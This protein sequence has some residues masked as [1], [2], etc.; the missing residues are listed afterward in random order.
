MLRCA[1]Q[2][3][4]LLVANAVGKAM[5]G[6]VVEFDAQMLR[7]RGLDPALA[8]YFREAP[9]FSQ[10]TWLVALEV[11]G[12]PRG[13]VFV[14]FDAQGEPCLQPAL[15]KAAGVRSQA[16]AVSAQRQQCLTLREGL[17]AATVA[18][19]PGKEQIDLLVPTDLLALPQLQSRSFANGGVGGVF[20]YDALVMG[21]QYKGQRSDFR[22]VGSEIGLNAGSWVLR[23]RQSYTQLPDSTRFEHLYAYGTRTLEAYEANVQ[24]GQLNLQSPLFA[25]ESFNGVQI[26]PEGAFAQMRA[27]QEGAR[28]EVEGIAWSPSRIE[29]R[30]N[31]VLIYTTLV[32]GGPFTLRALPL[33]S[34][35]LDLEVS[36]HEQEGQVRRFR[37]PAASL[38]DSQFERADGFNLALGTVRRQ[39]SDDRQAPSFATLGREW[40]LSRALR[41]S[42]GILGGADYLSAGWGLQRQW[43]GDITSGVRQVL[44]SDRDAGIAGHQLQMTVSAVLSPNLS[45]SV[46]AVRRG[47]GFRTLSDTGWNQQRGRAEASGREHWTFALNGS[48]ERWGAFGMT[49]S[50]YTSVDEPPNMRL[51]LSWSQTLPARISLSLSLERGVGDADVYRRG[52]SAYLTVGMP[53]GEQRRARSYLRSDP[54]SG[55]R[56][57]VSM[58][59]VLS[60]T[61]AYSASAEHREAAAPSLGLRVNAL[62]PY[63]HVDLGLNQRAGASEF[64]LG[65]RGG[66][67]LH[68]DGVTLSPYPLRETFAVLK[69]GDRAGLKLYTPQGPVWTDDSGRAVAASL[70]PY[71]TARLEV[72]P[73]SLPR[74]VEVLYGYQ[75]VEAGRGSV[76]HLDFS[77][78]RVRRVLLKAWTLDRQWLPSGLA[79]QDEHG[80][81][82]TTVLEAGT[83]FLPDIKPGQLLRVQLSDS[84][85]C[86]LQFNL[87]E[88]PDEQALIEPVDALC[89]PLNLT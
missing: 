47:Q 30:Q 10:G 87:A 27:A 70:P 17:P 73:L 2:G 51:G 4:A 67:A 22:S 72:D 31:G 20:N 79:V 68:R 63:T 42:G 8:A 6:E 9:R 54:R 1:R 85:H 88:S 60:E 76:Q 18:L 7:E 33:L 52:T 55:V 14:T 25:G 23:S 12:Q 50:R 34:N 15:L 49:W 43:P 62:A 5:A 82:V 45:A 21:S 65:L 36:V 53:L 77:I 16:N 28:G 3:L 37:V 58:S 61:L 81:Y 11:N 86:D 29:V 19:H 40:S 89:Q 74:N 64:D 80:A 38:Q 75:E 78:T 83:I 59:E 48:V 39:G 41:V 24:I 66:M 13:R 32:P 44:S 69:A 46:V 57:G 84:A 35:Q 26:L 56:S 71:A